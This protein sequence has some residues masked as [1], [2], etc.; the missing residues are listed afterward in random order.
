MRS[1]ATPPPRITAAR[2]RDAKHVSTCRS[3]IAA[4]DRA[5]D[6]GVRSLAT[7]LVALVA[8]CGGEGRHAD[9]AARTSDATSA[10]APRATDAAPAQLAGVGG[11]PGVYLTVGPTWDAAHVVVLD[12]RG[13]RVVPGSAGLHPA[14]RA[15]GGAWLYGKDALYA[16]DGAALTPVPRPPGAACCGVYVGPGD[17]AWAFDGGETV[18]RW[19]GRTWDAWTALSLGAG[20]R[21]RRVATGGPRLC[22]L[23]DTHL[24]CFE[25]EVWTRVA[26]PA[27]RRDEV[28]DQLA[29]A[30]DGAVVVTTRG[31]T[32]RDLRRDRRPPPP[33][34]DGRVLALVGTELVALDVPAHHYGAPVA[35]A[36]GSLLH[37]IKTGS[38]R[39]R[40]TAVDPL[41]D[42]LGWDRAEAITPDGTIWA[43]R[44][45]IAGV[46]AAR[47]DGTRAEPAPLTTLEALVTDVTADDRGRVWITMSPSG[48]AIIDGA[49]VTVVTAGSADGL[50]GTV[51]AIAVPRPAPATIALPTPRRVTVRGRLVDTRGRAVRGGT[52]ELCWSPRAHDTFLDPC[53][54][55]DEPVALR[56]EVRTDRDGRFTL[57]D[58]PAGHLALF[59]RTPGKWRWSPLGRPDTTTGPT[60][61]DLGA[62]RL[63]PPR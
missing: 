31:E 39:I 6:R 47:A 25:D 22:A 5:Y 56:R 52:V 45:Q 34:P 38:V 58:V 46:L 35:T 59:G 62:V 54:L 11:P 43:T 49:A 32:S 2:I 15:G 29:V 1:R 4:A 55:R 33:P 30:V 50:A 13:A 12:E 63:A 48:F 40:G 3:Q 37:L 18:A 20:P 60:D 9:D 7:G 14:P 36:D 61:V 28:V 26:L 42:T 44:G 57:A 16:W 23:S 41:D 21:W 27:M 10:T 51:H 17:T 8:A 24:A 53:G 19:N